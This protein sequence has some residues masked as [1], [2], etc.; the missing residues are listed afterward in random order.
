MK[1]AILFTLIASSLSF[2]AVAEDTAT[3]TKATVEEATKP[4]KVRKKKA[5]MCKDCGKPESQCE[6]KGH[7]HDEEKEKKT[8]S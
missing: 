6:C 4:T 1:N 2:S 5:M 8:S 7:G 3:T